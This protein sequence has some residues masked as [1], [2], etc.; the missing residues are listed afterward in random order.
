[1]LWNLLAALLFIFAVPLVPGLR[2][3]SRLLRLPRLIVRRQAPGEEIPPDPNAGQHPE[4]QKV[5]P[6]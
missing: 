6:P 4:L 1:V 2:N 5:G 3:L